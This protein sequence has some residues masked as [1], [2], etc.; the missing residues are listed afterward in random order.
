MFLHFHESTKAGRSDEEESQMEDSKARRS[1]AIRETPFYSDEAHRAETIQ[2]DDS[3]V[4][5]P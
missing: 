2:D 4:A 1:W 5:K 3:P